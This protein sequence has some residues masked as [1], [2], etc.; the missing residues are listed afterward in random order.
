MSAI[1]RFD[2]MLDSNKEYIKAKANKRK[3]QASK[4]DRKKK[5]QTLKAMADNEEIQKK[6]AEKRLS[7]QLKTDSDINV[8]IKMQVFD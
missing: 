7:D 2:S 5:V 4:V 6:Y 8:K 1:T 3:E